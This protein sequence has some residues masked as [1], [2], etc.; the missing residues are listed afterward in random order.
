MDEPASRL[1]IRWERNTR[2]GG[3][4][5]IQHSFDTDKTLPSLRSESGIASSVLLVCSIPVL[6]E[7]PGS[8]DKPSDSSLKKSHPPP[9]TKPLVKPK[10]PPPPSTD[11]KKRPPPSPPRQG[12]K[13]TKSSTLEMTR[14]ITVSLLDGEGETSK[15]DNVQPE[16]KKVIAKVLSSMAEGVEEDDITFRGSYVLDKPKG[17]QFLRFDLTGLLLECK[18]EEKPCFMWIAMGKKFFWSKNRKQL[19]SQRFGKE[20]FAVRSWN[21]IEPFMGEPEVKVTEDFEILEAEGKEWH[22]LSDEL[23]AEWPGSSSE[24]SGH[25]TS[26]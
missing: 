24:D 26:A 12:I 3:F 9:P 17:R 13:R 25:D 23:H 1:N 4:G 21:K 8:L 16:H 15:T 7:T 11:T 6:T 20:Y 18:S 10:S 22:A 5:R 2:S 19:K 14:H